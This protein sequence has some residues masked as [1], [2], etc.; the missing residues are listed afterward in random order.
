M[1]L[2]LLPTA[3]LADEMTDE[4]EI[5]AEQSEIIPEPEM[6]VDEI[7][8]ELE[9]DES[10]AEEI[11]EAVVSEEES[12]P[13]E[14]EEAEEIP[15]VAPEEAAD[16]SEQALPE[17][18]AEENL[19]SVSNITVSAS[20]NP[21]TYELTA[22]WAAVSGA[23]EY[24]VRLMRRRS[25]GNE[26]YYQ[27]GSVSVLSSSTTTIKFNASDFALSNVA[28]I[29]S[30]KVDVKAINPV[31]EI[32]AEGTSSAFSINMPKLSTP[33]AMMNN[34]GTA[35]W[36]E[37]PDANQ[38]F[39][40]LYGRSGS[41]G[42]GSL[43]LSF[44]ADSGSS[45]YRGWE[46]SQHLSEGYSYRVKVCALDKNYRHEVSDFVFSDW[47][48]YY[49]REAEPEPAFAIEPKNGVGVADAAYPYSWSTSFTPSDIVIETYIPLTH[50]WARG[51]SLAGL[52]SSAIAY[53]PTF[54]NDNGES[55]HRIYAT[56]G[57][58]TYYSRIFTVS[59][60]TTD[61]TS[62]SHF[63]KEPKGGICAEDEQFE[64]SWNLNPTPVQENLFVYDAVSGN[65]LNVNSV[66]DEN[67]YHLNYLRVADYV[68]SHNVCKLRIGANYYGVWA[69]SREF[70]VA[71]E[72]VELATHIDRVN[73]IGIEEPWAGDT[74]G[75]NLAQITTESS[76]YVITSKTWWCVS[77][78]HVQQMSNSAV[79]EE[80]LAYGLSVIVAPV[81]D[82]FYMDDQTVLVFNDGNYGTDSYNYNSA[83]LFGNSVIKTSMA[84]SCSH[85]SKKTKTTKATV[86]ANGK[87]E[88]VCEDCGEVLSTKTI[89]AAKTVSLAATS[90]TYDGK[91]KKPAITVKDSKGNT[92]STSNYTVT[93]PSGRKNVGSYTVKVTFKGNYSGSKSLTFK[94][95]PK[96]TSISKVSAAK[97]GF[98]VTLKKQATQ[99]TGYQI[100]YSTSSKFTSP[101]TVTI[102]KNSTVSKSVSKLTKKKKYYIRVRT[103]K[104]VGSTYFYSAW[105]GAKNVTTKK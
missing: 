88:S 35:K 8:P 37:V 90:Y 102:T 70:Y 31:N 7:I 15:E 10:E 11:L 1:C 84:G 19:V 39:V 69:Y 21:S 38:Y 67:P 92:I 104:K 66:E 99:T 52:T 58:K 24:D 42:D 55:K 57:E 9:T 50:T 25:T 80:G 48:A 85:P 86:S 45:D 51:S 6:D 56:C 87:S 36:S 79:F 100:Q 65:W 14:S 22:S 75:D 101:K 46:L 53:S 32:I 30:W 81:D 43:I 4:P 83:G 82:S 13:E 77:P 2:S 94:I 61:T 105:S 49:P 40:E 26:T 95:N 29:D 97:A 16:T 34:K 73:I 64:I 33:F 93:Y 60:Y 71:W 28:G 12:A 3:V 59:W 20:L 72:K 76:S 18:V 63:T 68:D 98:K 89:Y 78:G 44:H 17:A 91:E 96:G 103:Y 41:S 23:K 62:E 47:A 54:V 27:V 74:V 5:A